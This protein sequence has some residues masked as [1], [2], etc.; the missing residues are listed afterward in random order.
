M[1]VLSRKR[2]EAFHIGE[3]ITV[4]VVRV[5]GQRVQIGI[6]APL[7]YKIRRGEHVAAN[8]ADGPDR[9]PAA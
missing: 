3:A 4:T 1:L 8:Q 7:D 2:N 5:D 6:D 9:R